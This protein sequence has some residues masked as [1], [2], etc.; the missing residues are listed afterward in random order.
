M[1]ANSVSL[2]MQDV[3]DDDQKTKQKTKKGWQKRFQRKAALPISGYFLDYFKGKR[4]WTKSCA[5]N[6]F[7]LI[8]QSGKTAPLLKCISAYDLLQVYGFQEEGNQTKTIVNN[9]TICLV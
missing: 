1:R 2:S 7:Q 5:Y 6:N 8:H 4:R 9:F 3:D